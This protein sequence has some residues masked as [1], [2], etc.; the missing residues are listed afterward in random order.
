MILS[1]KH[2]QKRIHNN[3]RGN[4]SSCNSNSCGYNNNHGN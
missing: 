1:C 2:N 4:I 3:N